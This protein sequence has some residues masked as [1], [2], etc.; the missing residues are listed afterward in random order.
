MI[1]TRRRPSPTALRT[2]AF[3]VA[4]IAFLLASPR[5]GLAQGAVP[6]AMSAAD[7]RD[8]DSWVRESWTARDGLPVNSINKLIQSRDGYIWAATYDGLVRYDG[9]RFTVFN[10]ANTPGLPSNRF[11]DVQEM[12]DGSLW[13]RTERY[14]LVRFA[15]ERAITLTTADGSPLEAYRVAQDRSGTVWV[16]TNR[17]LG[18]VSGSRVMPVARE[19]IDMTVM[20]LAVSP[21]DELHVSDVS[22]RLWH[23]TADGRARVIPLIG[24]MRVPVQHDAAMFFERSGDM[25]LG[26][27]GTA[28]QGRDTLR[29]IPSANDSD[30]G[31]TIDHGCACCAVNLDKSRSESIRIAQEKFVFFA[32]CRHVDDNASKTHP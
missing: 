11:I 26:S 30:G 21:T 6:N 5:A 31:V 19:T 15:A 17:G 22:G 4:A 2:T 7:T 13:L 1:V 16:G 9:V 14:D 12:Q 20:S 29:Q 24:G 8:A 18:R 23:V 28:W 3:L 25:V 27:I 10:T 32:W